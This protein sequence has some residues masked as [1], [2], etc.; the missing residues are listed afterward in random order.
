MTYY[1]KAD[2]FYS[3]TA[4]YLEDN[5]LLAEYIK[6]HYPAKDRLTGQNNATRGYSNLLFHG[7]IYEYQDA[8]SGLELLN[9]ERYYVYLNSADLPFNIY[10]YDYALVYDTFENTVTRIHVQNGTVYAKK[11]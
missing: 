4:D 9:N 11:Q 3:H 10:R 7:G 6:E 5:I 2:S 8:L 1:L